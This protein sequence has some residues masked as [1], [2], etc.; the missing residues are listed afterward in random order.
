MIAGSRTYPIIPSTMSLMNSENN[1]LKTLAPLRDLEIFQ[2]I[3]HAVSSSWGPGD[4]DSPLTEL[5]P[6]DTILPD[7]SIKGPQNLQIE[8][9]L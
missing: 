9:M 3:K 5:L 7:E 6:L 1:L 2:V 4:S 8:E